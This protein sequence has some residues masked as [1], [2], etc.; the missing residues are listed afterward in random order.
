MVEWWEDSSEEESGSDDESDEDEGGG[1]EII[2][3]DNV[4]KFIRTFHNDDCDVTLNSTTHLLP[5][6]A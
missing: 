4:K 3:I 5:I 6:V 2:D 1:G